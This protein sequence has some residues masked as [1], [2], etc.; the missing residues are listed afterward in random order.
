MVTDRFQGEPYPYFIV[1]IPTFLV[2]VIPHLLHH[3]QQTTTHLYYSP[4]ILKQQAKLHRAAKTKQAWGIGVHAS[5]PRKPIH[6]F[7]QAQML[8]VAVS[9][10]RHAEVKYP[11][12]CLPI[13]YD[14]HVPSFI[15]L[16]HSHLLPPSLGYL[17]RG[18]DLKAPNQLSSDMGKS[19]TPHIYKPPSTFHTTLR[20][21][22][23][24][25]AQS[26]W[27]QVREPDGHSFPLSPFPCL[28][29]FSSPSFPLDLL[30]TIQDPHI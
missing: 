2:I 3:A 15:P 28:I 22:K 23:T 7:R 12:G 26:S 30:S 1:V 27:C 24:Y 20:K 11:S 5:K 14:L 25:T 17:K 16:F 19:A 8:C 9:C 13:Y 10:A 4:P 6:K 29:Q 21:H 18:I